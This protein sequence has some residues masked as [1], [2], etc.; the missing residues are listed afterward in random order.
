M[1][2]YKNLKTNCTLDY[3]PE[4]AKNRPLDA[5]TILKQI[6]KTSSTPYAFKNIKIDLDMAS[7]LAYGILIV[8]IVFVLEIVVNKLKEKLN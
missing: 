6:S 3:I 8:I 2:L 1:K 5:E 7:L 4:T